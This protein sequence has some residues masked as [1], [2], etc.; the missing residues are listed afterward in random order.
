MKYLCVVILTFFNVL[1]FASGNSGDRIISELQ[2]RECSTDKHFEITL[3]SDHQNADGCSTLRTI[4]LSCDH[5]AYETIVSFSLAAY[6]A[7]KKVSFWL[8]GCGGYGQ[9]KVVTARLK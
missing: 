7:D 4:E 6:M 8:N 3:T 5:V 9:A 2:Q 1:A